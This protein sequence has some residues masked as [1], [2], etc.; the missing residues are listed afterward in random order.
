MRLLWH[1]RQHV[2][3][4]TYCFIIPLQFY[5]RICLLESIQ[6]ILRIQLLWFLKICQCF[7]KLSACS[8]SDSHKR[9]QNWIFRIYSNCLIKVL[10]CFIILLL[11]VSNVSKTPPCIIVSDIITECAF[12]HLFSFWE[13][14]IVNVLMATK[15]KS[16]RII[17]TELN[18]SGKEFQGLLMLFLKREAVSNSNPSLRRIKSFL[19]GL[20]SKITQLNLFFK[21]P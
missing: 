20:M 10:S 14:F 4:F 3:Q 1:Y 21:V 9:V 17:R 6:T 19:Q 5:Q 15:R 8:Q 7:R 16:I 18:G 12:E 11:F 13:I 2:V